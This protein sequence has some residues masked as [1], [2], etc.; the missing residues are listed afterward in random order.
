MTFS[1]RDYQTAAHAAIFEAW[2]KY[3][4]TLLVLATGLGKTI[5]AAN[6]IKAIQP[7]RTMVLAHRDELII[8]A[9]EKIEAVTGLPVEIEKADQVASTSL[10]HRTPVVVSSIQTQISGPKDSRRYLR[11]R[12]EDFGVL[13]CDECHHSVSKSW[14]E[15]IAHYQKNLELKLL[16]LTATPKRFDEKALGQLFESVAFEYGIRD[17][18]RDG[19][20]LTSPS[21]LYQCEAWT[22][23]MSEL[24]PEI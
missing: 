7:K 8:Q 4:S 12:P 19:G 10:F 23:R 6:V 24:P 11:F 16:G 9:K 5:C 2:K 15:V 17:A 1:D 20:W 13:I 3:R 14:K 22:F 18:I 21:N